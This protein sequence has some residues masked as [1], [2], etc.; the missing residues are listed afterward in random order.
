MKP[1]PPVPIDINISLNTRVVTITGPN[2]GGKT[3]AMK[4]L[5]LSALM[6]KSGFYVLAKSPALLPWFDAIFADIGDE[7]SLTQSLSTFSGHLQRINQIKRSCTKESLVLLDEVGTGTN[8]IEGAALGM[9]I[10]ESFASDGAGSARLT[11][12]STH[13]AELKTLKYSD[14]RFENASVEFNEETLKPTFKV[15]WGVPGRSN[16]LNISERLG[17]PK[18]ILAAAKGQLGVANAEINEVIIELEKLK[19]ELENDMIL[20]EQYLKKTRLLYASIQEAAESVQQEEENSATYALNILQDI[21]HKARADLSSVHHKKLS[22]VEKPQASMSPD[23]ERA[24]K[25]MVIASDSK[26]TERD[27]MPEIGTMVF[28]PKLGKQAKVVQVLAG[29]KVVVVQSGSLQLRMS[30]ADIEI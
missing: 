27:C 24:S 25:N 6:A 18:S 20:A 7:Q 3:A 21:A 26:L 17:V 4:T 10:L 22:T 13:H 11:L 5:G 28:V 30:L 29:K 19:R 23:T 14:S 15:L 12:A 16:A 9:S 2:T 8:P 1:S